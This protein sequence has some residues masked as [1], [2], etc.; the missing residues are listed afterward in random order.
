MGER[1]MSHASATILFKDLTVYGEYNGT[2]DVMLTN[3]FNTQEQRNAMW[4]SQEWRSG[5]TEKCQGDIQECIVISHYG[6]CFWWKGSGCLTCM[7]YLGPCDT[8]K[9]MDLERSC[10]IDD[11]YNPIIHEFDWYLQEEF[12]NEQII[13]IKPIPIDEDPV[14]IKNP[15]LTSEEQKLRDI[16]SN[17]C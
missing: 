2:S 9:I 4:R 10:E 1:L 3:M 5:C 8:D 7:T 11:K 15:L 17:R 6:G 12:A 14:S 13:D 16:W